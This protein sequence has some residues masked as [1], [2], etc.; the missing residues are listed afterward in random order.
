MALPKGL[1]DGRDRLFVLWTI[2]TVRRYVI[3]QLWR[4]EGY[5]FFGY[6]RE[7]VREAI[8]AGFQLLPEFPEYKGLEDPYRAPYLFRTF[9]QRIPPPSRSDYGQI[10][11]SWGLSQSDDPFEILARS[12]GILLTDRIELSEYRA[13]D[14]NLERPLTFR[15]AGESHYQHASNDLAVGTRLSLRRQP[16]NILDPFATVV[17]IAQDGRQVGWVPREYSQLVAWHLDKGREFEAHVERRLVLPQERGR[18][19]VRISRKIRPD[20]LLSRSSIKGPT[21]K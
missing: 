1:R 5:Y 2:P 21:Q 20:K 16:D 6:R 8:D 17:L 9:Q 18:W 12:G 13:V 10:L 19:V 7:L 11:E 4:S 3:G 15:L 14:D